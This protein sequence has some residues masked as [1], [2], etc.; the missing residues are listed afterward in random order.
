MTC[1]PPPDDSSWASTANKL[2]EHF[3]TAA[4]FNLFATW[5]A[6]GSRSMAVVIRRMAKLLDDEV[7]ARVDRDSAERARSTGGRVETTKN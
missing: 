1:S 7:K 2:C 6:E 5:N 4:A 3:D